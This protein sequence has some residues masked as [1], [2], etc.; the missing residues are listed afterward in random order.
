MPLNTERSHTLPD[1]SEET[2]VIIKN[3]KAK[4]ETFEIMTSIIET[5]EKCLQKT[6]TEYRKKTEELEEERNNIL[7]SKAK[8]FSEVRKLKNIEYALK[9][10][11]ESLKKK[12]E[13]EEYGVNNNGNDDILYIL[14]EKSKIKAANAQINEELAKIY[15][16]KVQISKINILLNHK[17][18]AVKIIWP[19]VLEILDS[20]KIID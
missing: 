15:E 17:Q 8:V 16:E 20:Y 10:R 1:E 18:D 9:L 7:K 13:S 6:M 4:E 12:V 19:T 14:R 2:S 3:L 5:Q 11:E